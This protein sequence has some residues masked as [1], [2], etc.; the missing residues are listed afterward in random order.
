MGRLFF[1]RGASRGER[2]FPNLNISRLF[3]SRLALRFPHTADLFAGRPSGHPVP[4]P[5]EEDVDRIAMAMIC[6]A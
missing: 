1:S 3:A 2:A 6:D 5:N 4:I